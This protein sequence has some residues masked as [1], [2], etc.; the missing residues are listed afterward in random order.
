[1]ED[2][3]HFVKNIRAGV[4]QVF[5][6]LT[7][8][9]LRQRWQ[10]PAN[11]SAKLHHF[12]RRVVGEYRLSLYYKGEAKLASGKTAALEDRYN[13]SFLEI[14]PGKKIVQSEQLERPDPACRLPMGFEAQFQEIGKGTRLTLIFS[15]VPAVIDPVV[16][17]LGIRSALAK[18]AQLAERKAAKD[19][20]A[21]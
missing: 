13:A 2:S 15:Q 8:P 12:D 7:D 3:L 19:V 21:G 18:L 6:F 14:V 20:R 10:V 17:A 4:E 9:L 5:R 11:M 16:H 1:M